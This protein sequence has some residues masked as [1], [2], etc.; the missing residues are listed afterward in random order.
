M[1]ESL[2]AVWKTEL[3]L[4][5]I[6]DLIFRGCQEVLESES[7]GWKAG[8]LQAVILGNWLL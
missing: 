2:S 8:L 4:A 3:R 7:A 6:N 1:L 5:V